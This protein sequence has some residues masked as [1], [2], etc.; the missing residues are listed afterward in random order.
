MNRY[1][2]TFA[3]WDKVA[4]QYQQHFMSIDMYDDT[5]TIFCNEIKKQQAAI[6]EVGCGPGN[7]TRYLLAKLNDFFIDATDI[8]P[9]MIALAKQNNPL[10]NCRVM[11][12]REIHSINKKYD[13]IVCGFCLPYLSKQDCEKLFSDCHNLLHTNGLFYCS[14]IEGAYKNSGYE[15]GST[16]DKAY[17]YYYEENYLIEL[18]RQKG[19]T[20]MQ[21]IK[22]QY[23]KKDGSSQ[24]HLI[25]ISLKENKE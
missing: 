1:E 9:N 22:K 12:A 16:G 10:A 14:A 20:L 8:S 6:L 17:V 21:V 24:I 13:G 18:L 4:W 25:F 3:T 23:H 11:D 5:Y 15:T 19:F 7:I 2:T